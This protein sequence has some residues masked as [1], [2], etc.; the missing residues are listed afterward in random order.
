MTPGS[1]L[2]EREAQQQQAN[3]TNPTSPLFVVV[4]APRS[5]CPLLLRAPV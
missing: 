5:P 4:V 2:M 1:N 3:Q